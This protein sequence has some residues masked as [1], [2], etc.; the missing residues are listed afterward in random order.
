MAYQDD[1]D[2]W[3]KQQAAQSDLLNTDASEADSGP[4]ARARDLLNRQAAMQYTAP[5]QFSRPVKAEPVPE[6][7]S[8]KTVLAMALDVLGNKGRNLGGIAMADTE[9][10]NKQLAQW[11]QENS[12]AA[13]D[14]RRLRQLQLTNA[15][16]QGFEA[17]RRVLG[18]QAAQ[19]MDIAKAQ[20]A[21]EQA[22]AQAI[23]RAS[24][25]ED[26]VGYQN[27]SLAQ[28]GEL[29]GQRMEQAGRFHEDDMRN[30]A[31]A[32]AQAAQLAREQRAFTGEQNELNRSNAVSMN[33][34]DN[35]ARMQQ[36]E[37]QAAARA[38][39][40]K[41]KMQAQAGVL[42]E[43]VD[44]PTIP[45]T[46]A[47]D[48][49]RWNSLGQTERTQATNAAQTHSTAV[50]AMEKL[51]KLLTSKRTAANRNQYNALVKELI[52]DKSKEGSTGVLS[53]TE[54][55]RYIADLPEYGTTRIG[56]IHDFTTARDYLAGRNPALDTLKQAE[57]YA[58][59]K[60]GTLLQTYGLGIDTGGQAPA[61]DIAAKYNLEA[62]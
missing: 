40:N 9:Q 15:D 12:P 21:E 45:G 60:Y 35:A 18:Q 34:A 46:V 62:Y 55:E 61:N 58:K 33:D 8:W 53:G 44:V 11:R 6:R 29:A 48:R 59:D 54:Y 30:A 37:A 28:Q 39:E 2:E 26:T 52:G 25:H 27:R 47:L 17:D 5:K 10:R 43:G 50:Q 16:R 38:A 1:T 31:A 56:Q 23:Q 42:P 19:E 41:A 13:L 20:Q 7:D 4:W 14:A 36:L 57:N 32:R 3:L 24:E 49:N 22:R 51:Q